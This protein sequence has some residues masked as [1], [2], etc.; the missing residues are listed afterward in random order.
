LSLPWAALALE[1]FNEREAIAALAL[2]TARNSRRLRD[3]FCVLFIS[4]F[5]SSSKSPSGADKKAAAEKR[6]KLSCFNSNPSIVGKGLK[7][8]VMAAPQLDWGCRFV[9]IGGTIM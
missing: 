9:N 6:A 2:L 3:A 7:A 8:E 5:L 4:E 1:L